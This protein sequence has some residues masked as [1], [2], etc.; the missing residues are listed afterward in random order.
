MKLKIFK[1]EGYGL[2]AEVEVDGQRL[3]VMDDFSAMPAGVDLDYENPE[4]SHLGSDSHT[5]EQMFGGNADHRKELV[6]TGDWSY[7]AYGQIVS[8]APV[9]ADFGLFRLTLGDFTHDERCVGEWILE[10]IQRLDMTLNAKR[11]ER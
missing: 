7:D 3:G 4:F 8:I 6:R 11:R 1:S 5:W 2:Q 10:K 9:V